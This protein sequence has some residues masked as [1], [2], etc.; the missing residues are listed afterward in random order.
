MC[1]HWDFPHLRN[2]I[3]IKYLFHELLISLLERLCECENDQ[4]LLKG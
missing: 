3:K 4:S 1:K 2:L